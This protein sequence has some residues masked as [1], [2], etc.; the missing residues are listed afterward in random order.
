[1]PKALNGASLTVLS[2]SM[3]PGIKPGDIVV[4]RGVDEARMAELKI[5]D[6]ITFMPYA[7]DPTLV[8][9]RII[10]LSVGAKGTSYVTQGDNNNVVDPW[11]PVQEH[12][13]RGLF[14]YRVP[15][16]GW[17]RAWVGGNANWVMVGLASALIGY[18]LY[19][20]VTGFRRPKDEP[21]SDGEP[22]ANVETRAAR[23]MMED[24]H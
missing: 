17:A 3:E 1:V 8:T 11:G 7:D 15:F 23:R 22:V 19:S 13:I 20:V 9:H 14:A 2:G 6:V 16:L 24:D 12:Q 10:G 5:G 21:S 18:G 4:T